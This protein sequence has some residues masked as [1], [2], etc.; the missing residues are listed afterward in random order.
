MSKLRDSQLGATMIEAAIVLFLILMGFVAF[1]DISRVIMVQGVLI[2]AAKQGL[3]VAMKTRDIGY[4]ITPC[5]LPTADPDCEEPFLEARDRVHSAGKR[6]ALNTLMTEGKDTSG[7]SIT[8]I[9]LIRP[10]EGAGLSPSLHPLTHCG[11]LPAS[12]SM[13]EL[14]VVCPIGVRILAEVKTITPFL[15]TMNLRGEAFGFRE[16]TFMSRNIPEVRH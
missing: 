7:A 3:N 5:S 8:G 4:D 14:M 12:I 1:I 16:V 11:T 13:D 10:G 6:L 15:P 2:A 9:F